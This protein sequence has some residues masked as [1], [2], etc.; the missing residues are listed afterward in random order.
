MSNSSQ[1]DAFVSDGV[2]TA[3]ITR[4]VQTYASAA[5]TQKITA[6][7]TERDAQGRPKTW[8][9]EVDAPRSG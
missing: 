9:V 2:P 3:Q 5:N 7:V 6:I 1:A 8:R 4:I